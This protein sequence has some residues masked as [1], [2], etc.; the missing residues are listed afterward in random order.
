MV[1]AWG[2]GFRAGFRKPE[3]LN[4]SEFRVCCRDIACVHSDG[5]YTRLPFIQRFQALSR[6]DLFLWLLH[7]VPYQRA[8]S[9]VAYFNLAIS[10]LSLVCF[11][12]RLSPLP[13]TDPK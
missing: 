9:I 5:L 6:A 10:D 2:L 13:R 3:T 11:P 8:K 1:W 12:N 4:S 7:L